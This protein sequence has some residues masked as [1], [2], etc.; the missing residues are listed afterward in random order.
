MPAITITELAI[1]ARTSGGSRWMFG[2]CE[3]LNRSL[4]QL[5]FWR[6]KVDGET[7]KAHSSRESTQIA[8][9]GDSLNG[10]I[11]AIQTSPNTDS[12][13]MHLIWTDTASE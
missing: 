5:C 9:S 13:S 2:T 6:I 4:N 1:G 7:L 12:A 8:I 10:H 11:N 3:S